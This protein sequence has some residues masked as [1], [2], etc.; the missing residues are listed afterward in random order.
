VI[1]TAALLDSTLRQLVE[2]LAARKVE[3]VIHV[4]GGSAVALGYNPDRPA[5]RDVDAWLNASEVARQQVV[6]V[7]AELAAE[8][9]WPPNWLNE[10][11]VMFIPEAVGGSGSPHW[12]LYHRDDMVTI[13]VATPD[14]LFAMKLHAARGRRDLP[15]LDVLADAAGVSS[16]GA[17]LELFDAFYP[18]DRL[19][20]AARVWL[21][22]RF[23]GAR[24]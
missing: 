16:Q 18:H 19:K 1:F 12:R 23:G 14:V 4:V 15:D 17:A 21:E 13:A 20:P 6:A 2:R 24:S 9:G 10:N 11:A 3:V 7:V 8:N 22:W 5:T